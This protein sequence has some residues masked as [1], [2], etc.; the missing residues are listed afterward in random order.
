MV[1]WEDG[2][3]ISDAKVNEDGSITPA[4][5]SGKTPFNAFT[6]NLAQQEMLDD[7]SK[8]YKGT[9]ITAQTAERKR[10]TK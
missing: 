4:R 8:T 6:M 1:N 9:N 7:M 5:Y 2:T 10:N 3:K